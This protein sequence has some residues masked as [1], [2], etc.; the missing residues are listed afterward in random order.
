MSWVELAFRACPEPV[1]GPAFKPVELA[2]RPAFKPHSD[3]GALAPE[4]SSAKADSRYG[5]L[6]RDAALKGGSTWRVLS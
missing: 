1:E 6:S 4:V 2:F 3:T 5:K